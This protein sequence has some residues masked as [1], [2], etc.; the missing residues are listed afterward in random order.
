MEATIAEFD[1]RAVELSELLAE[2]TG[3]EIEAVLSVLV[4]VQS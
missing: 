2:V 4:E 3:Q 1:R